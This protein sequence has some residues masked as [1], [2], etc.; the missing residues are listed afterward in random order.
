MKKIM[1]SLIGGF[2]FLFADVPAMAC[3]VCKHQ[4]PKA[5]QNISH[6]TGPG[7]QIDYIILVVA[8]VVVA[9]AL[10]LSIKY[11]VKPGEK[12]AGHIKNSVLDNY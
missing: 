10:V 9:L 1:L 5:L 7:G 4:Q 3:E 11:L 2:V 8:G 12:S 6:G